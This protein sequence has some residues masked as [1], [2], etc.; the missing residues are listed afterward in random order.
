LGK[1]HSGCPGSVEE[2]WGKT[3][4]RFGRTDAFDDF[5]LCICARFLGRFESLSLDADRFFARDD[6]E[7]PL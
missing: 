5:E 4:G 1:R 7:F 3:C 2:Q 6:S